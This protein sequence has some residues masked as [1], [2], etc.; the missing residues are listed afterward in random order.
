MA[1]LLNARDL[2]KSFGA[3]TLFRRVSLTVEEGERI[4]MIGPNGAGK[5]TLLQILAGRMEPDDGEVAIRKRARMVYVPQDSVYPA[6]V[7]VE[8]VID[9]ALAQSSHPDAHDP[10][11]VTLG[12]AGFHDLAV[13]AAALS[14]GWRK[15]LA[16]VSALVQEP[17]LLLLDEPTNHLDLAGIEWL[18]ET[19]RTS[20]FATIVISHDRYFLES[21]ATA[22]TELNRTYPDGI[23]RA[24]GSY[25]A[26][27]EK[28]AEYLHA[29]SKR[30]EAIENKV[31]TE[32]EWLRRGPKARTT[33][34]KARIDSAHRLMDELAD[35]ESRSQRR[36]TGIDFSASD[37]RTK[38]LVEFEQVSLSFGERRILDQI[39]FTL[40]N[41]TRLG[42]VGANGA[43]KTT[44]MRLIEGQLT[45]NS[46]LIQRADA[47][48]IVSFAQD[49]RLDPNLSL[50][51]ALSPDGDSV[52][53][54][55]RLIHVAAWAARFL[56]D[57]SQLGQPV[58]KLSGGER[59]RVLIARL[60]LEPADVLLL[61]EPT[62]DLDIPTLEVLEES[63]LEF[64]GAMVLVTHDRYLLDRVSTA[65]VGL[66][67]NGQA[68]W[69]ASYAQWEEWLTERRAA[70]PL[71]V[72]DKAAVADATVKPGP[73][74]K[75]S[76]QLAREYETIEQRV[77]EADRR[78]HELEDALNDPAIASDPAALERAA[79]EL[80]QAHA[81]ADALYERWAEL[82]K[83]AG[84]PDRG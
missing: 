76:Y 77:E 55:G 68:G 62:N 25:T 13:E 63:L 35:L 70:P 14:G 4:G 54:R 81:A 51:A 67:G 23:F 65:V 60:M 73:K 37:R 18:E 45:P 20:P 46:G 59:A 53:Y 33:K 64:P 10:A 38:R 61:D 15:R 12:Q 57:A 8:Q 44:I 83:M 27:L 16:I 2:S 56:F 19:L 21:T 47:L 6:G 58:G 30:Q 40:M 31:R 9:E 3:T 5:S 75:L 48:R 39:S 22:V 52:N 42:L 80:A 24:A 17:D 82:E 74:K 41:G 7:R 28:R 34:S 1:L 26:F 49:R 36:T 66:D 72:V 29:Q 71:P 43:G 32:I 50:K 79:A 11:V 78:R 84:G 69:F